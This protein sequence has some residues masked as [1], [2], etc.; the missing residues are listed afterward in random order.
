MHRPPHCA[1]ISLEAVQNGD[2]GDFGENQTDAGM[3]MVSTAYDLT[4]APQRDCSLKSAARRLHQSGR[5][6]ELL[7]PDVVA[8]Q[9]WRHLR[10]GKM[11]WQKFRPVDN[12]GRSTDREPP[13]NR[14]G[15]QEETQFSDAATAAGQIPSDK[16]T[17]PLLPDERR[18]QDSV[19]N[20]HQ[21][22]EEQ[23][24][25]ALN[26][27]ATELHARQVS[28]CPTT[29]ANRLSPGRLLSLQDELDICNPHLS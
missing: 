20:G 22:G 11:G 10:F 26:G 2:P 19:T 12:R 27:E 29:S 21:P 25:V 28:K 15:S 16:A 5:S 4:V 14:S 18:A 17:T 9:G 23:R 8:V 3:A 13:L 6:I 24:L 7:K 1:E